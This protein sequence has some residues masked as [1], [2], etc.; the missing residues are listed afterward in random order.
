TYS[1]VLPNRNNQ[2]MLY[3]LET[4]Q[5]TAVTDGVFDSLNPVFDGEN[6]YFL[7]YSNFEIRLDP[8]QDNHIQ[9]APT[10]VMAVKLKADDAK[11]TFRIDLEGL[12][13]RATALAAKPG[14]YFHLKAGKGF[15]AWAEAEGWDDAVNE[16]VFRPRGQDK[17]KL[18]LFEVATGRLSVITDSVS[19]WTFS[20]EGEHLLV[21]KGAA[22][23]V[24]PVAQAAASKGL[25][26]RLDLERMSCVVDPKAE[27]AQIFNDTWR[28]YRDFFYDAGMNGQDWD[29]LG[30]KFKAWLPE[31]TTRADL[32]WLLSQMVG[33]LCV[34]HTYVSGGDFGTGVTP[35]PIPRF[36]GLLGADLAPANGGLRFNKI[37]GPTRFALDLKGPL[38]QKVRE[39]EYLLAVDG[40]AVKPGD[41]LARLL[42]VVRG[43][44]VTLT[45]NGKPSPEGARTVEVEPVGNDFQLRYERWVAGNADAVEKGSKGE[46][47]YMHISAMGDQ[48]IGQFDKFWRAYRYRKG[49]VVDVRGN[50]GGWTEF[51][52]I[53]KLERQQVGFNVLR[54]MSPFRYP[55]TASDRRYLFLSNEANGSDGEAFLAH[56]KARNLGT[57]VGKPSWGGLVGIIN[58]Q[59]TLDGGTVEQSNNAFYGA[60][61]QWWVENRG[62]VPDMDVDNDPESLLA[63]RDR[64]L[65]VG[66]DTLLKQLQAHPT[67][68]LPPVPAYPKR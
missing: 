21:R 66:I 56:V 8:S 17:W 63:G 22:F 65:E 7:S 39:G 24:G 54:G 14:N 3:N 48:N 6:L 27:W 42:Q 49:L 46:L 60:E 64:Q 32:N 61:G 67:P 51:F 37:Y 18:N 28:W 50:G 43:Q 68:A 33:E 53:D 36:T 35:T 62:A 12:Q 52:M 47:G 1:V 57:I 40:Q 29:A 16:E 15:V 45:V 10:R 19:D 38:H 9:P 44:K 2:V 26:A 34:S 41:N 55:G 31:M 20:P 58:T 13:D 11:G 23:H 30:A 25:G 4:K 5:R 59:F